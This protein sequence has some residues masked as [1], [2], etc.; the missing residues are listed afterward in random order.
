MILWVL[1][2]CILLGWNLLNYLDGRSCRT[3]MAFL[4]GF[5]TVSLALYFLGPNPDGHD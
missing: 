2:L 4:L 1:I 3:S 5:L